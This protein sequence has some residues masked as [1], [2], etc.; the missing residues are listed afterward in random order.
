MFG[1]VDASTN[2]NI[3]IDLD[4][5]FIPMSPYSIA[6]ISGYYVI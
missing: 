6:K 1:E 4:F 2:K 5:P 3:K